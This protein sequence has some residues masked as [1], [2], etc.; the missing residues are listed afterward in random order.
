MSVST[1]SNYVTASAWL[2][3]LEQAG[4]SSEAT[5]QEIADNTAAILEA[6]GSLVPN[7][8]S[9]Q[10]GL[11]DTQLRAD[12]VPVSG[13]VTVTGVVATSGL[14]DTELRATPV[15]VDIVTPSDYNLEVDRGN[16]T[17]QMS[18][19]IFGRSINVESGVQTDI[20]DRA[21]PTDNQAVW[22]APT[23]ARIH[24]IASSSAS[25]TTGGVGAN[26]VQIFYLPDWNTAETT[27][28]VTGNLNAGIA[29]VNGAVMINAMKVIPQ[30]SSTSINVGVITATAAVDGTVTAQIDA[31]EG[32]TEMAIY[33]VPSTQTLYM[34]SFYGSILKA[35]EGATNDQADL[36]LLFNP[37]VDVNTLVYR[38]SHSVGLRTD[39]ASP[40]QHRLINYKVYPGPCVV[41][42]RA[43]GSTNDLTVSAGFSG[44][45]V[46]T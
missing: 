45:I 27:E 28:T 24:T 12:P 15:Q 5:S 6:L 18:I 26:S 35:S 20:W 10:Y 1:P 4:L 8:D 9:P 37:S 36:Q 44:F 46:T 33:G 19:D 21:N 11:T 22:L 7:P 2:K 25:D 29:M 14:T 13:E 16:I 31:A 30:A 42:M 41:K 32:Q 3:V 40:F 34:T 17:G 39:G 38:V 43:E 23:A